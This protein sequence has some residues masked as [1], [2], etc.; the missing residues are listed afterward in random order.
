MISPHDFEG[1]LSNTANPIDEEL[2]LLPAHVVRRREEIQAT[3][4]K[5]EAVY[6]YGHYIECLEP[7]RR[8]KMTTG[9]PEIDTWHRKKSSRHRITSLATRISRQYPDGLGENQHLATG[10]LLALRWLQ[11]HLWDYREVCT[12][13]AEPPK[14]DGCTRSADEFEAAVHDFETRFWY[15]AHL[16]LIEDVSSGE[17]SVEDP[18]RECFMDPNVYRAARDKAREVEAQLPAAELRQWNRWDSGKLS[19]LRWLCGAEWDV[20]HGY[21]EKPGCPHFEATIYGGAS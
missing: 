3:R 1:F 9:R 21:V 16:H 4:E 11:G 17:I 19:A 8:G 13:Y 14:P 5:Y 18:T 10:K 12:T 2:P 15:S 6:W 7:I 20:P